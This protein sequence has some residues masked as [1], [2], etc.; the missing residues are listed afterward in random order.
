MKNLQIMLQLLLQQCPEIEKNLVIVTHQLAKCDI[1][2]DPG[3]FV[4]I[5]NTKVQEAMEWQERKG[6]KA[7]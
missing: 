2:K 6:S 3:G 7:L 4:D 1:S 5:I